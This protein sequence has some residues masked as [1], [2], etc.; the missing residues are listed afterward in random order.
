MELWSYHSRVLSYNHVVSVDHFNFAFDYLFYI[1]NEPNPLI[2]NL[3]A[4]SKAKC[5]VGRYADDIEPYFE[6]MIES[7]DGVKGLIDSMYKYT[8]LLK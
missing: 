7:K 8:T 5:R 6:L 4:K 2:I 1:D 3:L